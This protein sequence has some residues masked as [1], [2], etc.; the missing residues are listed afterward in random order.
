MPQYNNNTRTNDTQKQFGDGNTLQRSRANILRKE[1]IH[2]MMKLDLGV[3]HQRRF[4][5]AY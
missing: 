3:L 5:L 4:G 1:G 2:M